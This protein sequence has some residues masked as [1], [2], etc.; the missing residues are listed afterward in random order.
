MRKMKFVLWMAG[1]TFLFSFSGCA[2]KKGFYFVGYSDKGAV[3]ANS[4]VAE[5]FNEPTEMMGYLDRA[6]AYINAGK[7]DL[8][9]SDCNKALELGEGY[10]P[11]VGTRV[12]A[13]LNAGKYD[14]AIEDINFLGENFFSGSPKDAWIFY[15][16][17]KVYALSG[18]KERAEADFNSALE[19]DPDYAKQEKYF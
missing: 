11:A 9:I 4:G 17:G 19:L 10:P 8:A 2:A 3:Y 5:N 7:Y 16:R 1:L 12:L 18:D 13:Y 6:V 15:I 14:L